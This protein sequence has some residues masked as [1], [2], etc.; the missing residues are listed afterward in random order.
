MMDVTLKRLEIEAEVA[1]VFDLAKKAIGLNGSCNHVT[2][3]ESRIRVVCKTTSVCPNNS[4]TFAAAETLC[5]ETKAAV[6]LDAA[7]Q[8]E[9]SSMV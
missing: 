4:T 8:T 5:S 1:V 7:S 3:P 2:I 9:A 6:T